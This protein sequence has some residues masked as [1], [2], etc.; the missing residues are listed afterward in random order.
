MAGRLK[1]A[2]EKYALTA[3]NM[4]EYRGVMVFMEQT[5]GQLAPVAL[6]LAGAGG[7]LARELEAPL[8]GVLAGYKVG[9]VADEALHYGFDR[10]ILFD[11]PELADYRTGPYT[12]VLVK[13]VGRFKPEIVLL[14]ATSLGRDLAGAAAT[15][16]ATGLTADCTE[17]SIDPEKRLL[18]A[19][20][21]TFGGK[22]M[23]TIICEKHRPQM[24]T[25]RPRVMETPERGVSRGEVVRDEVHL[26]PGDLLSTVLEHVHEAG[27]AVFL[28]KAEIIVA[29]GRG[30]GSK[31]NFKLVED[32]ARVL[33]GSV[34]ASRAAV[35]AGW[36]GSEHQVGQTGTT[37][38][39]RIYFAIGIS[40]A[41]QHLV[42][43]QNSDVIVA[44]NS[45]PDAPIMQFATYG[46]V[47]DLFKLVPAIKEEF[48]RRLGG[49]A[50]QKQAGPG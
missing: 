41:I 31:E 20:R 36:I 30:L 13:A 8:L 40:G 6:E 45:D 26:N 11:D 48:E 16:L 43:M 42:G 21:P 24:A 29:G 47:G 2:P 4:D 44:V 5:R 32:L 27:K 34:G 28:D 23:A 33:G 15:E 46:L 35:D 7:R 49:I 9:S 12:S 22:Q 38:R 37:V 19:T 1:L 18:L 17:L 25:V 10:V 14:G 50:S 39:P 3:Q